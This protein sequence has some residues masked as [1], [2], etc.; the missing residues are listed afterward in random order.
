MSKQSEKCAER[1]FFPLLTVTFQLLCFMAALLILSSL[2]KGQINWWILFPLILLF[3]VG[4]L[5]IICLLYPHIR[6]IAHRKTQ[7]LFYSDGMVF[8]SLNAAMLS[9]IA[10]IPLCITTIIFLSVLAAAGTFL[11][12]LAAMLFLFPVAVLL[13]WGSIPTALALIIGALFLYTL[14]TSLFAVNSVIFMMINHQIETWQGFVY[15]I[16]L[17]LPLTDFIITAF[18][19]PRY[20]KGKAKEKMKTYVFVSLIPYMVIMIGITGVIIAGIHIFK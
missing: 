16:L 15:I 9:K 5:N 3:P 12:W 19:L 17:L 7:G 11:G 1:I 14:I 20:P 13:V 6:A 10:V 4:I 18:V 2:L 8:A